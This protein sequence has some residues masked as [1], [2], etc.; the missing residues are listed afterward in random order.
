MPI[1]QEQ[2]SKIIEGLKDNKRQFEIAKELGVTR[3]AVQH[4]AKQL[5]ILNTHNVSEEYFNVDVY[6]KS[7]P[8]I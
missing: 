1:S 8:T 3:S 5:K 7:I 4:Y 6:F 2:R